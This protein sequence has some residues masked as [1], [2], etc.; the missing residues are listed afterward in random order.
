MDESDSQYQDDI[1]K[2]N[3]LQSE[4]WINEM[5]NKTKP[6]KLNKTNGDQE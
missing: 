2:L 6:N 5:L 1:D 4:D 3:E